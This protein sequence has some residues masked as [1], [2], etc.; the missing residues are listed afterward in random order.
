MRRQLSGRTAAITALVLIALLLPLGNLTARFAE[1]NA[2]AAAGLEVQATESVVAA[3]DRADQLNFVEELNSNNDETQTTV[4]F[5]DG[6]AIGPDK[7][8]TPSVVQARKTHRAITNRTADGVEILVPVSLALDPDVEPGTVE[9]DVP[10]IR[11]RINEAEIFSEVVLAWL[12][13]AGLGV[14]LMVLA[15]VVAELLTRDLVRSSV[16]LASTAGQLAAGNLEKRASPSGPPEIREVGIALNRLAGRIGELLNAEREAAADLSHRMR[17]PLMALRLEVE[18]VRDPAQQA[19][20]L[21]GVLALSRTV[22]EVIAEVR[23]PVR[24]ELDT[25]CDAVVVVRE[26]TAF[27]AALAEDQGRRTDLLMSPGPLW[28][29]AAAGDLGAAIDVLLE[30][31]FAHSADG[32]AFAVTLSSAE[33][34]GAVLRVTNHG[35]RSW[36]ANSEARGESPAGS[37]GLG[38]DIAGRTA[39]ASGGGLTTTNVQGVTTVEM[40]LGAPASG[41]G[42]TEMSSGINKNLTRG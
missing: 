30:N 21:D 32:A 42:S 25:S 24:D 10:V 11:V 39:R 19:R 9:K 20:I 22:D 41:T 28:V 29:K 27:W 34:G 8:T 31:V 38:L 17:T 40:T 14:G 26:R 15:I 23:R 36:A 13:L 18:E 2:L 6:D 33:G 7:E 4:L 5:A 16:D 37:T 12:I 1:E 35:S 3:Q